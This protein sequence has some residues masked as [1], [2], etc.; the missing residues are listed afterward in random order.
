MP[1]AHTN[2]LQ[3]IKSA[4]FIIQ[5][6]CLSTDLSSPGSSTRQ[7]ISSQGPMVQ[8]S[9]P[10]GL[11]VVQSIDARWLNGWSLANSWSTKID[12]SLGPRKTGRK[13][14]KKQGGTLRCICWAGPHPH[15]HHDGLSIQQAPQRTK[16]TETG[17]LPIANHK[18]QP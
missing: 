12:K 4:K 13:K 16:S 2:C 14:K 18:L 17:S 8:P 9:Q 10:R 5:N 15:I 7:F 11:K 6:Q 3:F 1:K